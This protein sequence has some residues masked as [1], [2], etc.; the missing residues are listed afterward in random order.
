MNP[1]QEEVFSSE[2]I[3][4][5]PIRA[6]L[7]P[8][9]PISGWDTIYREF[10]TDLLSRVRFQ[11]ITLGSICS[12]PQ[13][14]RLTEQKLGRENPISAQLDRHRSQVTDGRARFPYELREEVYRQLLRTIRQTDEAV[15][16]GLCLEDPSMFA[17]LDMREKIG[18]CNCVL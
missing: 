10:L 8:I 13:A 17:S 1:L 11:R 5:Y 14:M 12:Y 9:I 16:V 2:E 15:E 6:V 4:T 18:K 7:M 3:E